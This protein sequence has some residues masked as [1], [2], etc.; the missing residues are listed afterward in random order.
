MSP[1]LHSCP[2]LTFQM[3]LISNAQWFTS[4]HISNVKAINVKKMRHKGSWYNEV[5][6]KDI[7]VEFNHISSYQMY[8]TLTNDMRRPFVTGPL[9]F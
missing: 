1:R 5:I 3:E 9:M 6:A 7:T 8:G 4:D 2:D